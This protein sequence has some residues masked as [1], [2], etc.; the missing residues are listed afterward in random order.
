MPNRRPLTPR[1]VALLMS[2]LTPANASPAAMINAVRNRAIAVLMLDAGTRAEETTKLRLRHAYWQ[3]LV[4]DQLEIPDEIAKYKSGGLIP[5]TNRLK[6]ALHDL[7]LVWH[8]DPKAD[9]DSYLF[10][11]RDP[12]RPMSPRQVE[13]IITAAGGEATGRVITP[14]TL[15][16]T[17]IDTLRQVT[18]ME[19]VRSLARHL[20]LSSTQVY[21]HVTDQQ[22]AAAVAAAQRIHERGEPTP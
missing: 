7:A 2:T 4:R 16:H 17:F 20:H 18:D 14:H 10:Y 19:T 12:T 5:V 13:R 1:E 15:R 22:R 11:S 9:P 21:F 6:A 8:P 3:G